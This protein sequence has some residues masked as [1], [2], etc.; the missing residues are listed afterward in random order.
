MLYSTFLKPYL[1][2]KDAE[3]AH[4]LAVEWARKLRIHLSSKHYANLFIVG[5]IPGLTTLISGY[6][7]QIRLAWQQVLI[8]ME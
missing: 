4:E 5:M 6:T 8:K 3:E 2:Q 7:F 1:F